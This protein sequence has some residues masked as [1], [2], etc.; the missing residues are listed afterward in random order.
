[1][2]IL[3]NGQSGRHAT[4]QG[5]LTRRRLLRA[6]A[7]AGVGAWLIPHG[8]ARGYA[9]NEQLQVAVVG[10][11]GRGSGFVE[12]EGWSSVRQQIGG[13]IAALCDVNR[14]KAAP[15]FQRYPDVPKYEDFRVM[16]DEMAPRLDAVVVATP[17]HTH[18]AP[19]ACALR[20]GL[21]VFCEKGLTRTHLEART[22]AELTHQTGLSTQMGNQGG[23]NVSVVEH[24]WAG[25]LGEIREIHMWGGG[26]A[27]PRNPPANA[28]DVPDHLNWDLWLGPAAHRPYHPDWL[29]HAMWRDFSSGHPGWWGA[30]LWATLYKAMKL[31]SLWPVDKQPPAAGAKTIK[32]TAEVSEVPE[33]TFPRWRIVR[34]DVPARLDMPPLRLTWYSGGQDAA[35]RFR[36]TVGELFKK[37]PQWGSAD[38]ERWK[39]WVGNLWVGTEGVM[40]TF[41]HG[42]GTV[43][44]LPEAKFKDVG[45]PP[46]SLPRPLPGKFLRGWVQG[47]KEGPPAMGCFSKFSGPFVEWYLL[48][49]V[50]SLFPEEALEFDPVAC[51]IVNHAEADSALRPPYREGWTL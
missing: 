47:M 35:E 49:N 6:A 4:P 44:M 21:H 45:S 51:R 22:L 38:D 50:A 9:A 31:D 14:E 20:A 17:D 36:G 8:R 10:V 7:A 5:G 39:S 12:E 34:W 27:G 37:H 43:A 26:G 40:Y 2:T 25:T 30:H 1:M 16:I 15:A 11:G 24:V 48:A 19:S 18:A 3:N 29:R 23:Y 32:V 46:E 33:A 42:C 41:G 28:H 13:R